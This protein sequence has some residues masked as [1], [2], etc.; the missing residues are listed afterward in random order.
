M[1]VAA[2]NVNPIIQWDGQLLYL[3]KLVKFFLP[4]ETC[5][6]SITSVI[7][8]YIVVY[9]ICTLILDGVEYNIFNIVI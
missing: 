3:E 7:Y 5:D 1:V 6:I 2:K 8:Y 4:L 9:H